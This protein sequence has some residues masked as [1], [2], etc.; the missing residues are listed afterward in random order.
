M[1]SRFS[2][3]WKARRK[4]SRGGRKS[5]SKKAVP[6]V[7]E[8]EAA[9]VLQFLHEPIGEAL[10]TLKALCAKAKEGAKAIRGLARDLKDYAALLDG[11]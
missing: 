7:I 1:S 2:E 11:A 6:L 8:D 4:K 3:K 9:E 5:G 10:V